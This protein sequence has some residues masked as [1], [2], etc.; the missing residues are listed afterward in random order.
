[1]FL[2]NSKSCL[3]ATISAL[4]HQIQQ[5]NSAYTTSELGLGTSFSASTSLFSTPVSTVLKLLP[6]GGWGFFGGVCILNELCG[7]STSKA[8]LLSPPFAGCPL[9]RPKTKGYKLSQQHSRVV[10]WAGMQPVGH[11]WGLL[12]TGFGESGKEMVQSCAGSPR[13]PF[14]SGPNTAC[15]AN[16]KLLEAHLTL[17]IAQFPLVS[18][19]RGEDTE[20]PLALNH[21]QVS[22]RGPVASTDISWLSFDKNKPMVKAGWC[23]ENGSQ[24]PVQRALQVLCW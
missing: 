20:A 10:Q 16:F 6:S 4:Q 3:L 17:S 7:L 18:P 21:I 24:Q 8:S 22:V 13:P 23:E 12:E 5:S 15:A 14:K 2:F 11:S 9:A 1:M 19:G